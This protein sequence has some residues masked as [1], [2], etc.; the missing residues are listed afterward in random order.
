[1]ARK[2]TG[3]KW[4][5]LKGQ[6]PEAT[7]VELSDRM[8]EVFAAKDARKD[9]TMDELIAERAALEEEEAFEDLARADRSVKYEA[10][11]RR[12]LEELDKVKQIAGTDMW[13]GD[14]RTASPKITPQPIVED[15]VALTEWIKDTGLYDTLFTLSKP[16]LKAT[17]C[18]ALETDAA[19]ALTPAQRAAL[20][21]GA[22]G[23]GAPP[24]GVKVHLRTTVHHTSAKQRAPRHV[25]ADPDDVPF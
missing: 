18:E 13:R 7:P 20:K 23:S 22:P 15:I 16:R 21:P 17:V 2:K 19:A 8:V 11:D 4:S 3:G 25:A 6:F 14:G 24:P 12:I 5:N 10:L 9:A 1:M